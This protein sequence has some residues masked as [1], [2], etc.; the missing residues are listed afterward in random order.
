MS[1]PAGS[2]V[3]A[4]TVKP[5]KKR[6]RGGLI[7]EGAP[8]EAPSKDA[9]SIKMRKM[10]MRLT[11][12][13]KKLIT[14]WMGSARFTHNKCLEAVKNEKFP[15]NQSLLR[16]RFVSKTLHQRKAMKADQYADRRDFE[17]GAFVAAHPWLERTPNDIRD[18]AVRDLLKANASNHEKRKKN[19]NHKWKL[20][21]RKRTKPSG[22]TIGLP[23]AAFKRVEILDRPETR[24]HC[25]DGRYDGCAKREWTKLEIFPKCGLGAVW[26]TEAVPNGKIT[27]DCRITRDFTGHFY[28][29]VPYE[30]A[31]PKPTVPEAE[32]KVVALDPGVRAFQ[33][34]YSPG[35]TGA[36]AEGAAGFSAIFSLCERL[37]DVLSQKS[38]RPTS[39][40]IQNALRSRSWR[41][42]QRIRNLVDEAHKKV[43]LD[44]VRRFDTIV[45][46]VFE[47]SQM[48]AKVR[49][50]GRKRC[51]GRKTVRA[52]LTWGHYRFR[53]RLI[54]KA[55]EHGKEVVVCEERYTSKGCGG[56][57][58]L[59][60]P[61]S[62]KSYECKYCG[63]AADRDENAARN[64][65]LKHLEISPS[66]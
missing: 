61:G 15:L 2:T 53:Q 23:A 7:K 32:R 63:L 36:Y 5:R 60:D 19:P 3:C 26:L 40:R 51:I 37:D 29:C 31:P 12:P 39:P 64:I 1:F 42:R 55:L 11:M 30:V 9:G 56:C 47:T 21:Y 16:Q 25:E 24:K 58:R 46:P 38:Q 66:C 48:A 33:T 14:E 17:V 28:L 8:S 6:S 52:M 22:W 57:G 43:S 49:P 18:N 27:K 50:D 13:Q 45:I 41:L 10:R 35:C 34:Y 4:D 20:H 65:F 62:S 59:N 44:L 54:E